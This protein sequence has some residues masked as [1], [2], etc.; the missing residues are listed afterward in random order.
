MLGKNITAAIG[1]VSLPG[2]IP[3]RPPRLYV[4]TEDARMNPLLSFQGPNSS[5][6]DMTIAKNSL[7]LYSKNA[8]LCNAIEVFPDPATP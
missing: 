4:H 7:Y 1:T 2:G 6:W 5:R 8:I 3:S